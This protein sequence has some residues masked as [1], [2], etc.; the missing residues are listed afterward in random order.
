MNAEPQKEHAWL[1]RMV[2]EWTYEIEA[3]M[4]PG[5][6]PQKFKG[7]E[8]VRS[9]GGI[10]IVAEGQGEMGGG[11][12]TT[13]LTVGFDPASKKFVGSWI[14]SMMTYLWSYEGTLDAAERV[15][16]LDCEG[17]I[18]DGSGGMTKYKDVHTLISDNERTLTGNFLDKE[19]KW[20]EMMTCTYHRVR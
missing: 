2:G 7:R 13:I 11:V 19:G 10:W 12:A 4:Q 18:F 17:P 14:G 20:N 9:I 1:H 6:P 16:T 15:L 3:C 8:T 5:E